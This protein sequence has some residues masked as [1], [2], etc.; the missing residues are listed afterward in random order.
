[1]QW[2][3]L[4]L[5]IQYRWKIIVGPPTRLCFIEM[6]ILKVDDVISMKDYC[7]TTNK[8]VFYWNVNSFPWS[9]FLLLP[10]NFIKYLWHLFWFIYSFILIQYKTTVDTLWFNQDCTT[11]SSPCIN[12][13]EAM[14][15][16]PDGNTGKCVCKKGFVYNPFEDMCKP[17]NT[18]ECLCFN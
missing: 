13:A 15:S 17:G 12:N 14:C 18:F 16:N 3:S 2:D 4:K 11:L 6:W 10:L 7:W 9:F 5:M 1:M 8:I